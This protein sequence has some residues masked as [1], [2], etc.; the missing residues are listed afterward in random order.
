MLGGWA[1]RCAHMHVV[2]ANNSERLSEEF[3]KKGMTSNC[4]HGDASLQTVPAASG[5]GLLIVDNVGMLQTNDF[6]LT[7]EA[8]NDGDERWG[9]KAGGRTRALYPKG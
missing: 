5:G 1:R 2:D 3:R 6:F 7:G 8:P 9:A 4:G